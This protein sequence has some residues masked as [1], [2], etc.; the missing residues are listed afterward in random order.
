M[1]AVLSS[2]LLV[3]GIRLGYISETSI[4]S[5]YG[6]G[7]GTT[8]L[9]TGDMGAYYQCCIEPG[10]SWN[11]WTCSHETTMELHGTWT[12]YSTVGGT[13]KVQK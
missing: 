6:P 1:I 10:G 2:I 4:P 13:V 9:H 5:P 11:S 12:H 7:R 3:D 8:A